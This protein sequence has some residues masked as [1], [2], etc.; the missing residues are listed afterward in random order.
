M[1]KGMLY[2][3]VSICVRS[4]LRLRYFVPFVLPCIHVTCGGTIRHRAFISRKLLLT[5]L[6]VRCTTYPRRPTAVF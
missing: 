2:L 5:M 3:E 6:F 4:L 1:L